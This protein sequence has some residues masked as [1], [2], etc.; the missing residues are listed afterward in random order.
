MLLYS[1]VLVSI[2]IIAV[3]SNKNSSIIY[4]A[5]LMYIIIYT[6]SNKIIEINQDPY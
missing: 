2:K 4:G 3:K 1:T 5:I 6:V